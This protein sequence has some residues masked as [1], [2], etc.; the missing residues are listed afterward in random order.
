MRAPRAAASQSTREAS[1]RDRRFSR[2]ASRAS[3]ALPRGARE[4]A[5]ERHPVAGLAAVGVGRLPEPAEPASSS[6][7]SSGPRRLRDRVAPPSRRAPRARGCRGGCAR[8]P[9]AARRAPCVGGSRS[10]RRDERAGQIVLA[11][12]TQ[13][14]LLDGA[15][16]AVRQPGA[17]EASRGRQE[18]EVER[19]LGP[20]P[21]RQHEA[22]LEQRQVEARAVVGDEAVHAPAGA[23]RARPGAPAPRRGRA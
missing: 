3:S 8:R 7:P 16:P 1:Q 18:V 15:E 5:V 9:A 2:H 14:V 19:R 21:A 20:A 4:A 22:R 6:G 10:T 12:E 11:D 23:D 13:R 17:P